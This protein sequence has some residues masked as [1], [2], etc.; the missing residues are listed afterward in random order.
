MKSITF[1]KC[2]LVIMVL[3]CSKND[4]VNSKSP[5]PDSTT[6][7]PDPIRGAENQAPGIPELIFPEK[8]QLCLGSELIFDWT[9]ATDPEGN[10]LTYQLQISTNRAFTNM[11]EDLTVS[12]TKVELVMEK[13]HDYYWRVLAIDE[14][15]EKGEFSPSR[16]FYVEGE[17]N[18]NYIPFIPALIA[19]QHNSDI[20]PNDVVL[21]WESSD[22]DDD[23]LS[24]DIYLGTIEN[25]ELYEVGQ[26]QNSLEVNLEPNQNYFWKVL[27]SDGSSKSIGGVWKFKTTE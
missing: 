24:Y 5:S 25:P 15:N 19:P 22:L 10:V 11:V 23:R 13:G 2:F 16:A 4:E 18:S 7:S 27:V 17:A 3:S 8:D 12:N 14:S 21:Q 9:N 20:S 26:W 6:P 1:L